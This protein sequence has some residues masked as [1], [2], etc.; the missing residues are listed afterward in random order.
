MLVPLI[1]S[2]CGGKLEVENSQV[3]EGSEIV[4]VSSNQT[5]K[6]PHCGVQYMPGEKIK[7][8]RQ[9]PVRITIGGN[10]SGSIIMVGDGKIVQGNLD[11][12]VPPVTQATSGYGLRL[13]I[14]VGMI[15]LG[16]ITLASVT[17]LIMVVISGMVVGARWTGNFWSDKFPF[18]LMLTIIGVGS[19][20]VFKLYRLLYK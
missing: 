19:F 1:C 7:S 11:S 6:C 12:R 8:A 20:G 14:K 10:V 5:F 17:A 13:L 9:Q 18:M 4:I 3:L 2:Q 15:V 16:G